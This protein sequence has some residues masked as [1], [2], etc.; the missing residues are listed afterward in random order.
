MF[1]VTNNEMEKKYGW[2]L[3]RIKKTRDSILEVDCIFYGKQTS[4]EDERYE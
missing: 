2:R 1:P 3:K 4:F